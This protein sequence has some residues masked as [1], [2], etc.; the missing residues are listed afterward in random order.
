MP[1]CKDSKRI[2]NGTG[3]SDQCS[4][5]DWVYPLSSQPPTNNNKISQG[6]SSN[7]SPMDIHHYIQSVR[8]E[9]NLLLNWK[10]IQKEMIALS[11]KG[12]TASVTIQ[13]CSASVQAFL[14]SARKLSKLLLAISTKAEEIRLS[15]NSQLMPL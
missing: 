7:T 10:K 14:V 1:S 4:W 9:F 15:L 13:G 11:K 6:S 5:K 2:G 8:G 12:E 3:K